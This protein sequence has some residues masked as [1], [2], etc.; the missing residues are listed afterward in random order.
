LGPRTPGRKAQSAHAVL[1][2]GARR[3]RTAESAVGGEEEDV[4]L[5]LWQQQQQQQQQQQY[6]HSLV[7]QQ[8]R[9]R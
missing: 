1:P 3:P 6:Q 4:P 8:V 2:L 7:N 5:A 9:R